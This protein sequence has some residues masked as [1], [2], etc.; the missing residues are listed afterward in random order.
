MLAIMTNTT[1]SSTESPIAVLYPELDGELA[2]TRKMLERFPDAKAGWT[3]H[4]KSQT[5]DALASH[6]AGIPRHGARLIETDEL[7]VTNR[8]KPVNVSTAAELLQKFDEAVAVLRQALPKATAERLEQPWTMRAGPKV[9]LSAPRRRLLRDMLISHIVHHRAQ[10]GVYY[11]LLDVP[12]PGTYGPSAD[13]PI[14]L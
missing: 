4:T 14:A 8:P 5:I 6:I 13:E 10:L 1:L 12:V 7:D 9:I 11:R 3:P 2:K